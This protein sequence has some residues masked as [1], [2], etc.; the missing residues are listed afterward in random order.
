MAHL[1]FDDRSYESTRH[2][3]GNSGSRSLLVLD[4]TVCWTVSNRTFI[5]TP[6]GLKV[7]VV[8]VVVVVIV[9]GIKLWL[10]RMN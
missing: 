3:T 1:G 4:I 6:V 10:F 2:N 5:P 8:M 9:V 7:V